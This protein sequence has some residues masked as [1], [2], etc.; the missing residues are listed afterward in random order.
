M[1]PRIETRKEV[2]SPSRNFYHSWSSPAKSQDDE[3]E[4]R[5]EEDELIDTNLQ[6]TILY[7]FISL[8]KKKKNKEKKLG[9]D[10]EDISLS[11]RR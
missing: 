11:M 3:I 10:E 1:N 8:G 4:S 7:V 6:F 2:R 5:N 9:F